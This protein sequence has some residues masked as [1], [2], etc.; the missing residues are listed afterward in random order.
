MKEHDIDGEDE[1]AEGEGG[2]GKGR[3]DDDEDDDPNNPAIAVTVHV[4]K[5]AGNAAEGGGAAAEGDKP[6][7]DGGY[8]WIN[9]S[10]SQFVCLSVSHS[11][12][13]TGATG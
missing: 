4:V 13:P 8:A 7:N 2:G 12:Q 11:I 1:G 3:N 6:G 5:N 10:V 9:L